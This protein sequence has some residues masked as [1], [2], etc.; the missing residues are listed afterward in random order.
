MSKRRFEGI[1]DQSGNLFLHGKA[2]LRFVQP[3]RDPQ[4]G[5]PSGECALKRR[6]D[7]QLR[8]NLPTLVD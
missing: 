8:P 3:C 2:V 1:R 5:R 6:L 7:V 4:P